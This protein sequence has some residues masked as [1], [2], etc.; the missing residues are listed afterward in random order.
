MEWAVPMC[1][2]IE[3]SWEYSQPLCQRKGLHR[4]VDLRTFAQVVFSSLHVL[5]TFVFLRLWQLLPVFQYSTL[6]HLFRMFPQ[7]FSTV[8]LGILFLNF[9]GTLAIKALM[10]MTHNHLLT[11]LFS[12]R[13]DLSWRQKPQRVG[14]PSISVEWRKNLCFYPLYSA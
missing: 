1:C 4:T 7:T 11:C 9:P 13:S 3:G 14:N 5:S 10:T 2:E 6:C 12:H 8:G